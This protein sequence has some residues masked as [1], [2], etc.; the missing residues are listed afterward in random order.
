MIIHLHL[1]SLVIC[2]ILF[3]SLLTLFLLASLLI[4]LLNLSLGINIKRLCLFFHLLLILTD[5]LSFW[6]PNPIYFDNSPPPPS[7]FIKFNKN[8]RSLPSFYFDPTFIRHLR[9]IELKEFNWLCK[10]IKNVS[11]SQPYISMNYCTI[12]QWSTSFSLTIVE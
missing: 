2:L 12:N 11:S 3:W 10:H 9:V 6:P 7:P 4:C 1:L 5:F 8:L